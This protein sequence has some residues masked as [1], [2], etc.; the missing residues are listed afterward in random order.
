MQKSKKQKKDKPRNISDLEYNSY[1]AKTELF[2][3]RLID[4]NA[5]LNL[6]KFAP[7]SLKSGP[8]MLSIEDKYQ[9]SSKKDIYMIAVNW[10][11]NAKF[12][13]DEEKFLVVTA[14]FSVILSNTDKLPKEFWNLYKKATLPLI[15]YPYFREFVQNITSRMNIPPLTLP[16]IF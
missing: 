9:Y 1:L 11:L 2:E 4:A 14:K 15:V 3:V 6:D 8:I 10:S 16:I 13:K 12:E 7:N 5:S